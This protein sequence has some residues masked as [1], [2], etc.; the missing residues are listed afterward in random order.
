MIAAVA[1]DMWMGV[2]AAAAHMCQM[3]RYSNVRRPMVW[4][5]VA[6]AVVY[7]MMTLITVALVK[8]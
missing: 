3:Y 7:W 6:V 1:D 5:F 4:V 2:S 8:N